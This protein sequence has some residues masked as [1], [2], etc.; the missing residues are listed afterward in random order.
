MPNNPVLF[1]GNNKN[2]SGRSRLSVA[3]NIDQKITQ[4]K[5][6][7]SPISLSPAPLE[8]CINPFYDW[9]KGEALL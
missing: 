7:K 4:N 3:Q 9:S 2:S 8:D 5:F 1:P 6:P